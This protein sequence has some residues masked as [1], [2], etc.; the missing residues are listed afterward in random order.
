M[1]ELNSRFIFKMRLRA[2][3]KGVWFRVLDR[4]E[5]AL[6]ILVPRCMEE[7]R[8]A[9]LIDMLAKIIVKI[10]SALR[11]EIALHMCEVGWPLARKLGRIAQKW[12]HKTA[13]EWALDVG[14]A[15]FWT[16]LKMNDPPGFCGVVADGGRFG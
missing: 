9:R 2:L 10:N 4:T 7:A 11:G 6:L 15:R 16:I 8:S 14:F 5:R 3:R 13:D 1:I 12:G